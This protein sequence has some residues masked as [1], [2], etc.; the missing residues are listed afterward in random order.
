MNSSRIQSSLF[1]CDFSNRGQIQIG[2]WSVSH[3]MQ[4]IELKIADPPMQTWCE[5]RRLEGKRLEVD[6]EGGPAWFLTDF[7]I[8]DQEDSRSP[9]FRATFARSV[10]R[11]YQAI[12]H[13]LSEDRVLANRLLARACE[14]DGLKSLIR[15]SPKTAFGVQV[16]VVS[17]QETFLAFRRSLAVGEHQGLWMLGCG[18]TMCESDLTHPT[19][20]SGRSSFIPLCQRALREEVGLEPDDYGYI[21]ISWLGLNL[22]QGTNLLVAH[23]GTNLTEE[24]IERRIAESSGTYEMT[25]F[26]WY[27]FRNRQIKNLISEMEISDFATDRIAKSVSRRWV[28]GQLLVL[29]ELIRSHPALWA[30]RSENK[31]ESN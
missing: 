30:N 24:Q 17:R 28:P 14:H 4:G 16:N 10:Y 26:D 18:E 19:D 8:D 11:D 9:L 25:E 7:D 23:A 5:E 1:R 31:P 13:L 2:S 12:S 27:S 3:P 20:D 22:Q 29:R 21:H 6:H 15:G